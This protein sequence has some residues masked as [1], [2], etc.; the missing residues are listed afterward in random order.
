MTQSEMTLMQVYS[1]SSMES[2]SVRNCRK[3][4]SRDN[5]LMHKSMSKD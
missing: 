1:S 4:M 3:V 5:L 2:G